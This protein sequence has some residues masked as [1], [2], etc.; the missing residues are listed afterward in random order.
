MADPAE[1]VGRVRTHPAA[2][3]LALVRT[4]TLRWENGTNVPE[5]EQ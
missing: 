3:V 4:V 1:E 5:V 2:V